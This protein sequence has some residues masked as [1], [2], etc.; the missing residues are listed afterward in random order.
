MP[1]GKHTHQVTP[2]FGHLLNRCPMVIILSLITFGIYGII[3]YIMTRDEM[4]SKGIETIHPLLVLIPFVGIF[5]FMYFL[6]QYAAGVEKVTNGKYSQAI[7][8]I[9]LFLIG[10]IGIGIIQAAYNEVGEGGGNP[11]AD[12][13]ASR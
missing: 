8:F 6:W 7:A 11:S 4:K 13:F 2:G 3:W 12:P 10:F 1:Q 9:L 5:A